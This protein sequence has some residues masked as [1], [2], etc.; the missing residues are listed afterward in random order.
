M[1]EDLLAD[2]VEEEAIIDWWVTHCVVSAVVAAVEAE[3][4]DFS[5]LRIP[6]PGLLPIHFDYV[7]GSFIYLFIVEGPYSYGNLNAI[8]HA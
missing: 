4:L 6:E 1:V 8:C 3:L 2:V 5:V 7:L